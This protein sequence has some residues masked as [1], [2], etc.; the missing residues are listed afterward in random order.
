MKKEEYLSAV[1]SILFVSNKPVTIGKLREVL[2]LSAEGIL[3]IITEIQEK[4]KDSGI[5]LVLTK[6]GY[7]FIPNEKYKKYYSKFVKVKKTSLSRESI[8]VIAILLKSDATK[9]RIDRLRGVNST[10]MLNELM[11]RG[12]VVRTMKNGKLVY[13]ITEKLLSYLPKEAK[14]KL[15]TKELFG[16]Q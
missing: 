3:S 14:E 8:E 9:E 7:A 1:E 16:K 11:R 10:R 12:F 13:S 6:K 2:G 15:R 5:N 4:Y